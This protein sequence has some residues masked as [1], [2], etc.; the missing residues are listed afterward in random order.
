M[1]ILPLEGDF[2]ERLYVEGFLYDLFIM[3][4]QD[5]M[6][7]MD[8]D[9]LVYLGQTSMC[10]KKVMRGEMLRSKSSNY[11]KFC[12]KFRIALFLY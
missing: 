11:D 7:F 1:K 6:G 9:V 10:R 3:C 4:R 5:F 12:S 2:G 8:K